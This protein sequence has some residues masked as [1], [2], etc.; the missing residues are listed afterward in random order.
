[1]WLALDQARA[2]NHLG[3]IGF[4]CQ[5]YAEGSG[6]GV[7]REYVGHGIGRVMHEDP[8]VPNYGKAGS[9]PVLKE[10]MCLAIEPMINMGTP[11]VDDDHEDGW[12]VTTADG[13]PS[14]HFEKSVAVCDGEPLILTTEPG[15]R[16]PVN[17]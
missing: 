12:L 16:R 10:G 15:F 14:A 9:G 1:M 6:Y 8:A 17:E 13:M 5:Q 11:N 3:D 4:A 2:G 7:V